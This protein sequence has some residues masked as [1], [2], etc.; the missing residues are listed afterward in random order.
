M[1]ASR[2][3][4]LLMAAVAAGLAVPSAEQVP[5]G[6]KPVPEPVPEPP[7]IPRRPVRRSKDWH[8]AE[9]APASPRRVRNPFPHEPTPAELRAEEKRKRKAA[10]RLELASKAGR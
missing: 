3:M 9:S 2:R 6:R 8:A 7:P 4:G 10:R 1:L 5:Q